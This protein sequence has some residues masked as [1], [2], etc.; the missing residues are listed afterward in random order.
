MSTKNSTLIANLEATPLVVNAPR[1]IGGRVRI[2]Q[3]S[4]E[5]ATTDI[6]ANDIIMLAPI[7]AGAS[8]VSLMLAS[9]D[10]DTATT[11]TVDVGLYS[12]AGVV[13][14][15]DCYA[16]A[17]TA[18]QAATAFTDYRYEAADIATAGQAVWQDAG[19]TA[20]DGNYHYVA[21]TVSAAGNQAGTLSF[22]IEY[23][24]D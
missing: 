4:I 3:G 22:K 18:F 6:E 2:A 14:D 13:E 23:V 15:V 12:A 7:P 20:D 19:L 11:M 5:L 17:V 1:V 16:S 8:I 21:V 10:L 9:D 24:V